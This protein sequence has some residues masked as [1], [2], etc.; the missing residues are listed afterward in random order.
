MNSEQR[1]AYALVAV[2]FAAILLVAGTGSLFARNAFWLAVELL[3][4]A[5]GLWAVGVMRLHNLNVTPLVKA[6]ARLVTS[7]PYARVRHPMYLAVLLTIWPLIIDQFSPLRLLAGLLLTADLLLKIR[8]EERLLRRHFAGY[9]DYARR[10]A[11]LI[12]CLF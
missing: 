2:Q 3:G 1:K 12:P 6:D 8:F 4:I 7:G 9:D 5:L 10:T 11:R